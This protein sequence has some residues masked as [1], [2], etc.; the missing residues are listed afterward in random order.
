MKIQV[1]FLQINKDI[2]LGLQ[3]FGVI[4]FEI[5]TLKKGHTEKWRTRRIVYNKAIVDT[6]RHRWCMEKQRIFASFINTL[7]YLI[8]KQ[9]FARLL[10][11]VYYQSYQQHVHYGS[12]ALCAFGTSV[13]LSFMLSPPCPP[14]LCVPFICCRITLSLH[15]L[16]EPFFFM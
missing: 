12:V 4:P 6:E 5:R 9:W 7:V 14:P 1:Q 15:I 8:T 2:I 3:Q 13:L 11:N 16:E 10:K